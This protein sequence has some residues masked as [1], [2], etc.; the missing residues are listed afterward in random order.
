M[1]DTAMNLPNIK[2]AELK[3]LVQLLDDPD[4]AVINQI[5]D[6]ILDFGEEA[7]ELLEETSIYGLDNEVINRIS[8]L[9]QKIRFNLVYSKLVEWKNK[10]QASL[11]EMVLS[12]SAMHYPKM[13]VNALRNLMDKITR[14]V[15]LEMNED[16]TPL[17]K[18]Q[19]FNHIFFEVYSF[20]GNKGNLSA[21][22]NS[23]IKDVLESKKGNSLSM[24][25]LYLEIAKRLNMPIYGI[26][27]PQ[28]FVLAYVNDESVLSAKHRV[29]FYINPFNKGIIFTKKDI[30]AFL[31][32]INETPQNA[33]YQ[34]CDNVSIV[35]RLLS[36]LVESF[37]A[38]GQE[39]TAETY[40]RLSKAID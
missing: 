27:L 19:I 35:K 31:K 24:S 33:Y 26:D 40:K 37:S 29:L 4:L 13:D 18:V 9:V 20:Y 12:I 14:D 16:L 6:R 2:S 22:Q 5:E 28:N 3:A 17:E 10:D 30:D 23:L 34:V 38:V 25:I 11:F 21:P 32:Q 1:Q 8:E 15:W 7:I 39:D 36:E